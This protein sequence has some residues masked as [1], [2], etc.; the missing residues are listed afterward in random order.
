[1]AFA[2]FIQPQEGKCVE[3]S[4]VFMPPKGDE[5]NSE[6]TTCACVGIFTEEVN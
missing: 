5:I 4:R 2:N 3:I 1:M 6:L